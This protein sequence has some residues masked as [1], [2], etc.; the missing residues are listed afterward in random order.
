M[1]ASYM[2]AFA[3]GVPILTLGMGK[4]SVRDAIVATGLFGLMTAA[5]VLLRKHKTIELQLTNEHLKIIH[6]LKDTFK[7]ISYGDIQ[8]VT[9]SDLSSGLTLHLRSGEKISLG[10]TVQRHSGMFTVGEIGPA[11]VQ[12]PAGERLRLMNEILA[13]SKTDQPTIKLKR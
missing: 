11:D 7:E 12:G 9:F 10:S 3:C 6:P 1:I 5:T 13:K 8:E 4:V 2:G